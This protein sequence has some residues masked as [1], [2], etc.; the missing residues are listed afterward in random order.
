MCVFVKLHYPIEKNTP[1]MTFLYDQGTD[2]IETRSSGNVKV[3]K[4]NSRHEKK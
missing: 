4:N 1:K 2:T 3:E